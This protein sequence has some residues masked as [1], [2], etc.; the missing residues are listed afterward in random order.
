MDGLLL[1]LDIYLSDFLDIG[2]GFLKDIGVFLIQTYCGRSAR[3]NEILSAD[4]FY[5]RTGIFRIRI[6]NGG[7]VFTPGPVTG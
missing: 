6:R 7:P 5:T 2:S 3:A 1:D 4:L